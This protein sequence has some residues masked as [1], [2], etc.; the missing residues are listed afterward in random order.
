MDGIKR[1][2]GELVLF[3]DRLA[4]VVQLSDG[5]GHVMVKITDEGGID[6]TFPVTLWSELKPLVGDGECVLDAITRAAAR[7]LGFNET[8]RREAELWLADP[9]VGDVFLV[10][11]SD[12]LEIVEIGEGGT[13]W[14][15]IE[16]VKLS[17]SS[18]IPRG[19]S[20][21]GPNTLRQ[22]M[23]SPDSPVYNAQA[24]NSLR[25]FPPTKNATTCT[26]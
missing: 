21:A 25:P 1:E 3:H 2:L 7:K 24:F 12:R 26:G 17:P 11:P 8:M 15:S 13:I 10:M 9:Q 18:Q 4:E 6:H 5:A 16:D 22:W 23:R 14:A 19:I 20:F